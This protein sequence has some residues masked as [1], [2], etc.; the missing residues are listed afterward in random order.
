MPEAPGPAAVPANDWRSAVTEIFPET[1]R[2]CDNVVALLAGPSE[3]GPETQALVRDL[4]MALAK[5]QTQLPMLYQHA[6]G[7][8]SEPSNS[9]SDEPQVTPNRYKLQQNREMQH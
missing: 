2:V 6:S 1:L 3:A 7:A 8:L 9:S 4:Q 5:L